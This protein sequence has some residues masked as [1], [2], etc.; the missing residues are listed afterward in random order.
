[1]ILLVLLIN[2]LIMVWWTIMSPLEWERTVT[3]SDIYGEP[4]ESYGIC[5]SDN[6]KAFAVI[7]LVFHLALL[8]YGCY[9]CYGE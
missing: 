3:R 9:L 1:M 8:S 6:W 4:L 7:M 2:C 5:T